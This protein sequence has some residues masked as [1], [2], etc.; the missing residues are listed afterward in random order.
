MSVLISLRDIR[1]EYLMGEGENSIVTQAL[2]GVSFSINEGD[3]VAIIGQSGSGKST[4]MHILGFLDSPSTGDYVFDSR[5]TTVYE[6]DELADIRSEKVGFVFQAFNL[7]PRTTAIDNV[8]LPLIYQGVPFFE[9]K[10]RAEEAL[11]RVGLGDRMSHKPNELSGGQQ[12]RVAIARALITNPKLI[13]ADEPTG[14]LDTQ[15]SHEIIELFRKLNAE[16]KTII[17]VTHEVD[18][19]R[20]AKRIITLRDG[21]VLSDVLN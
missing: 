7:L 21:Q 12:Q 4:L 9:Q 13:L 20:S 10:Q 8:R 18:I 16:G 19:A 2:R 15:A 1:K 5:N 14:N 17:L 3:Y 11:K 6:E